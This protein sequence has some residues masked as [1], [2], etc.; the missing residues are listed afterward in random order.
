MATLTINATTPSAS[1]N[2]AVLL[3]LVDKIQAL[4]ERNTLVLGTDE[5]VLLN[6]LRFAVTTGL[7][8]A[9][10]ISQIVITY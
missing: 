7:P 10:V 1:T 5:Y 9:N 2:L 6:E 4:A 3:K 8:S